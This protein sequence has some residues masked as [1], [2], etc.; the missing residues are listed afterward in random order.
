MS[1]GV[2]VCHTPPAGGSWLRSMDL[3]PQTKAPPREPR[4][5]RQSTEPT[6]QRL[7]RSRI[8]PRPWAAGTPGSTW[9]AGL[10]G[11]QGPV[12]PLLGAAAR[13]LLGLSGSH[14]G[15]R[16][17]GDGLAL[18]GREKEA[19][20]TGASWALGDGRPARKSHPGTSPVKGG[21]AGLREDDPARFHL[22]KSSNFSQWSET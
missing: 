20:A 15:H 22:G 4:A 19:A 12:W 6:A 10:L 14:T 13:L 17:E 9:V 21:Q 5:R 16:H 11:P 8:P 1:A 18:L 2:A 7:S 3:L